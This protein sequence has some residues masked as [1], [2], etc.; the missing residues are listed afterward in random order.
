MT[1]TRRW[2]TALSFVFIATAL[3]AQEWADRARLAIFGTR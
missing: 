1:N 2:L 3:S